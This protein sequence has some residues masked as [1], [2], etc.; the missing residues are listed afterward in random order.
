MKHEPSDL[1]CLPCKQS[2]AEQDIRVCPMFAVSIY[3]LFLS[4]ILN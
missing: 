1:N 3:F 2:S 4:L